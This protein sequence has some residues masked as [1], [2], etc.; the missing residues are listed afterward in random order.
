MEP[1][2]R[3]RVANES[4]HLFRGGGCASGIVPGRNFAPPVLLGC[5]R[6]TPRE[7]CARIAKK[8]PIYWRKKIEFIGD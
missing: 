2:R 5:C 1:R 7:L 8:N 6:L 3:M 4:A